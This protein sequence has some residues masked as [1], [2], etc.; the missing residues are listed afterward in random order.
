MHA[1]KSPPN[2]HTTYRDGLHMT[3]KRV[4]VSPCLL[5][6]IKLHLKLTVFTA[7]PCFVLLLLMSSLGLHEMI[8]GGARRAFFCGGFYVIP[9]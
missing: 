7:K 8:H 2:C 6:R 3:W 4:W 1:L 5:N 9:L